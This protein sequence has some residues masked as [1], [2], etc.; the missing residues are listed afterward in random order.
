MGDPKKKHKR[1]ITPKRPYDQNALVEELR[2]L[3]AYGLR[4]KRELWRHRTAL[5]RLRR[6]ARETQSLEPV[7]RSERE[8]ELIT[9]LHGLGIVGERSSLED[10]LSLRIEDLL[11]RRFQTVVYRK[12]MAKSLFQARQLVTHGHMSIGGKKVRAPSYLVG[13]DDEGSIEFAGPSPMAVKEHPLRKELAMA[14]MAGG[15]KK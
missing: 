13:I 8:R 2:L 1:F 7:R 15:K 14:E 4:N 5:S 11:E 3:G 6:L 12:G 10:V 9:H